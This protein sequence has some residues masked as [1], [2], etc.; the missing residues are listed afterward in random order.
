MYTLLLCITNSGAPGI[1]YSG[2]LNLPFLFDLQSVRCEGHE[3]ECVFRAVTGSGG[4][5]GG[6][7]FKQ[8]NT[9]ATCA[10]KAYF[11]HC[12]V[13]LC[14]SFFFFFFTFKHWQCQ[15]PSANMFVFFLWISHRQCSRGDAASKGNFGVFN[16]NPVKI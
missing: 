6:F 16:A 5:L 1:C 7:C 3:V 9:D 11:I 14:R 13:C 15:K 4:K 10:S 2:L 8:I 12:S